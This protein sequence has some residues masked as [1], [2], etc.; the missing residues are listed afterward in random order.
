MSTL[1]TGVSVT[2]HA[3]L[4]TSLAF[5]SHP[6]L[7]TSSLDHTIRVTSLNH[8][9][10]LWDYNPQDWKAHD[11]PVLKVTWAHP[12][13]GVLLAS[14][15]VDGV[16]KLWAQDDVR[17]HHAGSMGR[18]GGGGGGGAG[19]QGATSKQST[20]TTTKKW[21]LRAALTDAR[22]TIRDLEFAPPEFGLKLA[23][24]SSDSHLRVWGCLDPVSLNDW[25]LIE[26]IDLSIL[27]LG[28]SSSNAGAG[29]APLPGGGG[30]GGNGA[31]FGAEAGGASPQKGAP[32]QMGAGGS[33]LG[34]VAGSMGGMGSMASSS[35]SGSSF[36]GRKGGTVESD[37]GWALSWCKE[38]WW[39][40]RIAVSAGSSGIIRVRLS[41]GLLFAESLADLSAARA[42]LFHLPDHAPWTNYLNLLPPRAS[43]SHFSST[44]PTSSLAWAPASGRSYQLLASGSRDGRARVWKLFTP[45]L[46]GDEKKESLG[47]EGWRGE[48]D[49]ELEESKSARGGSVASVR[50]EWNVTGTVLST[51][52]I[53]PLP[54]QYSGALA[55]PS[56]DVGPQAGDDAKV[57]LWKCELGA[58]LHSRDVG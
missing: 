30:G 50:V 33:S 57:R 2:S 46:E 36:E 12:E 1:Q 43:S 8:Q 41:L 45:S 14:G 49:A 55:D 17:N 35:G 7:A 54:I 15:G 22:G 42:Q 34:S 31:G 6:Y 39:G 29:L 48:M 25:S 11:A 9:S 24:V 13:F 56:S 44:P 21:V 47:E 26:D 19:G 51:V 40:E 32:G 18:A 5:S 37:G 27:P 28:P 38:A 4:I 20:N 10:G 52:R 3:D 23:A 53:I 58:G 16:V